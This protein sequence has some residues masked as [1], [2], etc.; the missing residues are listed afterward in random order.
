MRMRYA[1][2]L[3]LLAPLLGAGLLLVRAP[4]ARANIAGM[5]VCE[6]LKIGRASGAITAEGRE[7]LLAEMTTS[8]TLDA[9]VKRSAEAAR[10]R[11]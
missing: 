1:V 9:D 11:C 8:P 7:R 5:M 3:I 6:T 10:K 2:M 4:D